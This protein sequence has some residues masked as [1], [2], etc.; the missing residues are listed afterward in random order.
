M[1]KILGRDAIIGLL[2]ATPGGQLAAFEL[3]L[4]ILAVAGRLIRTG[5][6]TCSRSPDTW[7]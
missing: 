2:T 1:A 3:R 4:R 5:R 6:R 7:P